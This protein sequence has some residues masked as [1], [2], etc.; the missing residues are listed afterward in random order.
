MRR[1]RERRRRKRRR[2]KKRRRKKRRRKKRRREMRRRRR[3]RRRRERRKRRRRRREISRR[4][5]QCGRSIGLRWSERQLEE[6]WLGIWDLSDIFQE[7][8]AKMK[9]VSTIFILWPQGCLRPRLH[10]WQN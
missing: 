4:D 2:R 10:G 6:V 9:M 1:K 7:S 5:S 8:L 3:E